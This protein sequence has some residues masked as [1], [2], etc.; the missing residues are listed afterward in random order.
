MLLCFKK[1]PDHFKVNRLR[2]HGVPIRGRRQV[3]WHERAAPKYIIS[4]L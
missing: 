2:Q 3:P 1:P 4:M